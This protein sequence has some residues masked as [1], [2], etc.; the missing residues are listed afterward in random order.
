LSGNDP[1]GALTEYR[2]QLVRRM[3]ALPLTDARRGHLTEAIRQVEAT[4]DRVL[5]RVCLCG[6]T[7][8]RDRL[9]A[10]RY[11]KFAVPSGET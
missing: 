2:D 4:I 3:K 10:G 8:H 7:C 1:I 5:V 9:P 11:C 6:N